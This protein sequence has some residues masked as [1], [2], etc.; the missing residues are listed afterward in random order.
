[1]LEISRKFLIGC[2]VGVVV[3]I[4]SIVLLLFCCFCAVDVKMFFYVVD[5]FV[6]PLRVVMPD[7]YLL[8][9]AVFGHIVR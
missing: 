3:S 5:V 6:A 8:H 7:V 1:M 2:F 9:S 4:V